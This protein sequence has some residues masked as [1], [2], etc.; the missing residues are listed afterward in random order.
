MSNSLSSYVRFVLFAGA[1]YAGLLTPLVACEDLVAVSCVDGDACVTVG[2]EAKPPPRR[3]L[4]GVCRPGRLDCSENRCIGEVAPQEEVCDGLDND[5]DCE[6]DEDIDPIPAGE[7]DNTCS[8]SECGQCADA[9]LVCL[10]GG[11]V[12]QGVPVVESCDTVDNDCNCEV[13]DIEVVFSYSGPPTTLGLGECRPAVTVCVDGALRTSQEVLPTEKDVCYN[14]KD[15]DCDGL[16]DEADTVAQP[17]S[18]VLVVDRSASMDEDIGSVTGVVCS[19]AT[20]QPAP[21]FIAIVTVATAPVFPYVEVVS[22]FEPSADACDRLY[23]GLPGPSSASE[24]QVDGVLIGSAGGLTWPTTDRAVVVLTDEEAQAA[25][26]SM[27]DIEVMCQALD[28]SLY[29]ATPIGHQP[30]WADT[31]AVCG[32]AFST[33][34]PDQLAANLPTWFEPECVF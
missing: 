23:T 22:D 34:Y 15:D 1:V 28:W 12:C 24:Y 17:R 27:F 33:L 9:A 13:D 21:P 31:V 3:E 18:I 2:G 6:T 5:C 32:G 8:T 10:D 19:F 30:A 16:V 11:L 25:N 29:V 14:G 26:Y 20:T 4:C 7:E